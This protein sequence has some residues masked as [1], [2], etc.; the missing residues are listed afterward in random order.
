MEAATEFIQG[1]EGETEYASLL[2]HVLS[3]ADGGGGCD[4]KGRELVRLQDKV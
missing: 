4:D 3:A 1:G 2:S